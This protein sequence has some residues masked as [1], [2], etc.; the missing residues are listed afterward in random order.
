MFDNLETGEIVERLSIR[1]Y[2]ES[3]N[4]ITEWD[5]E[6]GWFEDGQEQIETGEWVM[7][8][9][10]HPYTEEQLE[11]IKIEKEKAALE[12]SRQQLTLEDVTAIFIKTQLNTVDI[13]DQTSLRMMNYYPSFEEIIGQTVDIGFKFTYNGEMYKTIQPTLLIQEH[14]KPGEGTESLYTRIDLERTGA[15][16]DPIPYSGNMALEYGKYYTQDDVVY[17]CNRDTVNP[18]HNALSE[19]VGIYVKIV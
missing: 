17:L 8:R 1:T 15:I 6:T 14:Y 11:N 2:D 9:I 4:R 19:L 18:V 3:G 10:Y 7:T 5:E 13:P 12:E 16:Y